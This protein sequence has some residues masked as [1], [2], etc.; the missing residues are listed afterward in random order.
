MTSFLAD[1]SAPLI[2]ACFYLVVIFW[3]FRTAKAALFYLYLWQLKEYHIGRFLDHFRTAQGEKLLVNRVSVA[4][5][6]I[7]LAL[8]FSLWVA[9]VDFEILDFTA[10]FLLFV[11][12]VPLLALT[13]LY[14][15]EALRLRGSRRPIFTKKVI[16]LFAIVFF[17]ELLSILFVHRLSVFVY[18]ATGW[19]LFAS[20]FFFPVGL[21]VIDLFMPIFVSAV[22]LAFQPFAV[23]ARNRIIRQAKERR[24]EFKSLK[25]IGITGSYGKTSTKEFLAHILGQKYH[26]LKTP[27]HQ[28]SEVGISNTILQSLTSKHEIF[29]CEM[30]AY[31]KGG[32]KLLAQ[33]VKPRIAIVTGVNE[34]HLATFGSMENL[35]SAEGGEEL[36]NILPADGVAILNGNN[37]FAYGL[38][39]ETSM[40]RKILCLVIPARAGIMRQPDVWAE[41]V[42]TEQEHVAFTVFLRDGEKADLKVNLVGGHNVEN[43]LLAIAAAREL[44]ISLQEIARSCGSITQELGAMKLRKGINGL[45]II[46]STYS[47][48]PD[49]VIAA[50]EYLKV[51]E[52]KRIIVMPCLIELGP[53]SK[54][55]HRRIGEKIGEVCDLAIITTRDKFETIKEGAMTRGMKGD[56]VLSMENPQAIFGKIKSF[57]NEG[58][59]VL[60]EGR[61]S[62]DLLHLLG[63]VR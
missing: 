7:L 34:Q 5:I 21:L 59:V 63:R 47:A 3:F 62:S 4:K 23:L 54:H 45:N 13:V 58:D 1:L 43:V 27:E 10:I 53:A 9:T 39:E 14:G 18:M 32:I 19:N 31:N 37:T 2:L 46:D 57:C 41:N 29:V 44:G 36:L 22:V 33:I 60:L 12:V 61:V 35:L 38:Y 25:V 51:W 16:L 24:Q 8:I 52:G 28:N 55:A 48:N 11:S 30:G 17:G 26:V 40:V 42:R 20:I 15:M 6:F 56:D 50:L 49:G